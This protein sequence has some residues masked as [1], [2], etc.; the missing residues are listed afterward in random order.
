MRCGDGSVKLT[1]CSGCVEV[2]IPGIEALRS[3]PALGLE[4]GPVW[5]QGALLWIQVPAVAPTVFRR[6]QGHEALGLALLVH[7]FTARRELL[8]LRFLGITQT[9]LR[10]QS[11]GVCMLT[12]CFWESLALTFCEWCPWDHARTATWPQSTAGPDEEHAQPMVGSRWDGRVASAAQLVLKVPAPM[13]TAVPTARTQSTQTAD[14]PLPS[15]E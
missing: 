10:G 7:C 13:G 1:P 12:T 5:V 3:L 9:Y 8:K 6:A 15:F 11:Q 14:L 4:G 2:K